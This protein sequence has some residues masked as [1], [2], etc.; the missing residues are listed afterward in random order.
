MIAAACGSCASH[1]FDY[2]LPTVYKKTNDI[3]GVNIFDLSEDDIE[4]D[5]LNEISLDPEVGYFSTSFVNS[6]KNN[7][8][9]PS[10][11]KVLIDT[12][13]SNVKCECKLRPLDIISEITVIIFIVYASY[14]TIKKVKYINW[15]IDI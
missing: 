15:N 5:Q 1:I 12:T 11:E 7:K 4:D 14:K 6:L 13:I 8:G 9:G 10:T 2:T 3:L